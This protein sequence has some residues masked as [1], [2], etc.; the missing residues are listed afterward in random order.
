MWL[1]FAI[2][3]QIPFCFTISMFV[4][5]VGVAAVGDEA[6]KFTIYHVQF[7]KC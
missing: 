5:W 2:N 7:T 1:Y 4:P 6:P 3:G